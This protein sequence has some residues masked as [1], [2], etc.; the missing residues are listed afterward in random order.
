MLFSYYMDIFITVTLYKT[1]VLL[2]C[3]SMYFNRLI[4]PRIG[5]SLETPDKMGIIIITNT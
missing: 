3:L 2:G 1:N 4:S 5:L